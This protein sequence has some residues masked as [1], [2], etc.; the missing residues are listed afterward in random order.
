MPETRNDGFLVIDLDR[1]YPTTHGHFSSILHF[2]TTIEPKLSLLFSVM[3]D[4][5]GNYSADQRCLPANSTPLKRLRPQR[6]RYEY[7]SPAGTMSESLSSG[8]PIVV[9]KA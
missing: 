1:L 4:L 7:L 2:Q 3:R 9:A 5:L 8:N 6:T